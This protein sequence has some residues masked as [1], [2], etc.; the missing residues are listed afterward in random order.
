MLDI[1]LKCNYDLTLNLSLY[2]HTVTVHHA[3]INKDT[4]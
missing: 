1:L 3:N 2:F 4:V